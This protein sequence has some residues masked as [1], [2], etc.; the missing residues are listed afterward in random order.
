MAQNEGGSIST[1]LSVTVMVPPSSLNY[2]Q[3][4][5]IISM[6]SVFSIIPEYIGESV[7]FAVLSGVLPD[8]SLIHILVP[9]IMIEKQ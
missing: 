1:T 7:T 5:Y 2:P 9:H 6:D 4:S 8:L 3:T